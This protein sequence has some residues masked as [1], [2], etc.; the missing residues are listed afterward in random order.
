MSVRDRGSILFG[1]LLVVVL[2]TLVASTAMFRVRNNS[3]IV[4]ASIR[5]D[6]SRTLLRSGIRAYLAELA[7]ADTAGPQ[8]RAAAELL[9]RVTHDD[10]FIEFITLPAYAR[11]D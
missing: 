8:L 2:A 10:D 3:D 9:E 1:V 11:L 6:S 7:E 5:G 4:R